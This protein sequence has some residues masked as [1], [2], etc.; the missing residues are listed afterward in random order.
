MFTMVAWKVG[1]EGRDQLHNVIQVI[2]QDCTT[3]G[4]YIS[5]HKHTCVSF[6]CLLLSEFQLD[7]PLIQDIPSIDLV[8]KHVY[9]S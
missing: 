6:R 4:K 2:T 8:F 7:F 1:G 3:T 9:I 5:T